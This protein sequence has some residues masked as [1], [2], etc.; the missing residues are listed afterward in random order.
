MANLRNPIDSFTLKDISLDVEEEEI[1]LIGG[2]NSSGK[3]SLL[4][5]LCAVTE[6]TQGKLS[7]FGKTIFDGEVKR[8]NLEDIKPFIGVQ[9]QG[10][11]L[12]KNLTPREIFKLFSKNYGL[13][14]T[15]E[16]ALECPFLEGFLD[17]RVSNLSQGKIQ[18]VK[19]LL[20]IMHD[21][22]MVLLD[23]PATNLDEDTREWVYQKIKE[24][25]SEGKSFL[26]TLNNLWRIADISDKLIVL[27]N[28]RIYDI[29]EDF[30]EYKSGCVMKVPSKT[31]ERI[32]E[33]DWVLRIEERESY[34]EVYS[35]F[36]MKHILRTFDFTYFE[37]KDLRLKDFYP[38]VSES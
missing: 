1:V 12:F 10:D 24:L 23:E 26:I 29:I 32:K 3:T 30:Q 38:G 17:K 4:E 37:I 34:Y 21:P 28:G 36:P 27:E 25:K 13:K 19:F 7:Y 11:R 2:K 16:I 22:K 18:L 35:K 14:R 9:F 8:G 20:S 15:S 31:V 33:E 5:T 6:P